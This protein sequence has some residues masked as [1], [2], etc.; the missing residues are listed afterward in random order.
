M[1]D[2]S[3]MWELMQREKNK[4]KEKPL[5][6]PQTLQLANSLYLA[7]IKKNNT[8][9][10]KLCLVLSGA[11]KQIEYNED[12]QVKLNVNELCEVMKITRKDLS[13]NL[14][15]VLNVHFSYV[16]S[17]GGSGATTPIHSYEYINRNQDVIIE[18]SS[19]AKSLFTELGKGKYSFSG[20]DANNLMN[21]KHKHSL[22]MQL[23]LEQIDNFDEDVAKRKR[24]T[25][26]QLN[27]YFEV[28][29][30]T[31]YEFERKILKP[32]QL[33]IINNSSLAFNYQMKDEVRGNGRPKIH[34]VIIDLIK[35]TNYQP[36]LF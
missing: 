1:N 5:Y 19:K 6:L 13:N 15:K 17:E 24:Y 4:T 16:T 7:F 34:E 8:I 21:L 32:V 30:A 36:K 18:I 22:R 27:A 9:G 20:A 11:K 28:H 29:Y 35:Q 25:L 23:L 33:E 10:L 14:K 31:Y 3:D 2:T 12:N 26:E